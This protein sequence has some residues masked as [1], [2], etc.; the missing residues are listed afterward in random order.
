[1]AAKKPKRVKH[2]PQ[3]TCVGCRATMPK[4]NLVRIVRTLEGV[5]IDPTGKLKGRG[6]Y[7]HDDKA[8]WQNALK[9]S[10]A[11]ALRTTLTEQDL[12]VLRN[13]MASL[14]DKAETENSLPNA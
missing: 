6:A 13:F 5:Q 7:L 10:L 3:R 2:V 11:H 14:N 12:E 8:C 9:G 4:R 1:M